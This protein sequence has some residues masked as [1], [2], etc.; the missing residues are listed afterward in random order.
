MCNIRINT[1]DTRAWLNEG[2]LLRCGRFEAHYVN[3]GNLG[4]SHLTCNPLARS[5]L[6][7][8]ADILRSEFFLTAHW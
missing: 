1:T 8:T 4:R 5:T 6:T 2:L 3:E 7:G